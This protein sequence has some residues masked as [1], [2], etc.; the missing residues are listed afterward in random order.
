MTKKGLITQVFKTLC[1]NVEFVKVKHTPAKANLLVKHVHGE[2][3]FGDMMYSCVVS[4][5]LY[6]AG[7]THHDIFILSIV[8]QD[9]CSSQRLCII[10][11][12]SGLVVICKD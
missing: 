3:V 2:P 10:I 11:P 4:M 1:L 12:S 5:I 8:L 7:H 6:L 9:V